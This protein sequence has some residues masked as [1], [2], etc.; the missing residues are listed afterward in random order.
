MK[1]PEKNRPLTVSDR[2]A[3]AVYDQLLERDVSPFHAA[4]LAQVARAEVMRDAKLTEL[5]VVKLTDH[6]G[7][8][9][10]CVVRELKPGSLL[11]FRLDIQRLREAAER[12]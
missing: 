4:P 3:L 12:E 10:A 6:A 8:P 7:Q 1:L 5:F 11:L 9:H 2:I